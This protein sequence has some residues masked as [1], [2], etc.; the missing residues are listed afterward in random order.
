MYKL[1]YDQDFPVVCMDES[2]KQLI[3]EL[4]STPM[5]SGQPKR[6]DYEYIRHGMVNV[7]IAN[8]PFQGKRMIEVTESK[9]KKD[10]AAFVKRISDEMYPHAKKRTGDG[11][12]E[13]T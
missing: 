12:S 8:E 4:A 10:W 7:F 13:Y 3:Q 5:K 6:V 2:P 11:Q 1:P 9:T